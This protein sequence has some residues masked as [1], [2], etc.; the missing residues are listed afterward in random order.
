MKQDPAKNPPA[1]VRFA[2]WALTAQ[3]LPMIYGAVW[4]VF[5]EHGR[6]PDWT[7]HQQSHAI[8]SGGQ[9]VA[10]ALLTVW[11]A[12]G[13]FR[14]GERWSGYALGLAVLGQ[15]GAL[16]L[17]YLMTGWKSHYN[18]APWLTVVIFVTLLAA[19]GVARAYVTRR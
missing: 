19:L 4:H 5:W 2:I 1:A 14:R 9:G 6:E 16:I 3:A 18:T 15:Y 13:P 11:L 17:G 12:W 10:L 7:P 8:W